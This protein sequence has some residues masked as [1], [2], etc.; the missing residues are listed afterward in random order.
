M[1]VWP[2]KEL[3]ITR[4]ADDTRIRGITMREFEAIL[5]TGFSKMYAE[6][7]TRITPTTQANGVEKP[8][9][10]AGRGR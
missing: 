6:T 3:P 4:M 2:P 9:A 7:R 1:Q 5:K 8:R 10:V